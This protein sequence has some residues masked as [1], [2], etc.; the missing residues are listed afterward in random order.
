M[1]NTCYDTL[2]SYVHYTETVNALHTD[3][4]PTYYHEGTVTLLHYPFVLP[5]DAWVLNRKSLGKS[6]ITLKSHYHIFLV[7]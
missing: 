2:P 1:N 3:P 6:Y 7:P 4:D 5:I